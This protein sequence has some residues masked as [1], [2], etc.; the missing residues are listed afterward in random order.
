M[1]DEHVKH[2][3]GRPTKYK[4]EYAKQASVACSVL[5]ATD[6]DLADLFD[7]SQSTID[8]WKI[9]HPEFLGSIK[10]GK[11]ILDS[12]VEHSLYQRAMGY[13]T[14]EDKTVYN[15]GESHIVRVVKQHP[16]DTTACIFWLKNRRPAQWRDKQEIEM[17][18]KIHIHIDA[19]DA[20][21]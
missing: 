21:V 14:Y 15:N 4:P 1:S 8:N 10:K 9:E 6:K 20:R 7:V 16:P 18:N 2:A 13:E 19:D 11:E 3:G 17:D 12:Q 5:G